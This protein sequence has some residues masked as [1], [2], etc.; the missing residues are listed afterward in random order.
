[1]RR[2]ARLMRSS[3]RA[4]KIWHVK[5]TA[6]EKQ[7]TC[8]WPTDVSTVVSHD[9]RR[10]ERRLIR[11]NCSAARTATVPSS[12]ENKIPLLHSA[13]FCTSGAEDSP[14]TSS[15]LTP[16]RSARVETW[17]HLHT[18]RSTGPSR[19]LPTCNTQCSIALQMHLEEAR[20]ECRPGHRLYERCPSGCSPCCVM[21]PAATF[22]NPIYTT[23]NAQ[24]FRLLE[25]TRGVSENF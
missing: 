4:I 8:L 19:P 22:V 12:L 10:K 15:R 6:D 23:N 18:W 24:S 5:N 7:K 3:V 16:L 21:R 25:R 9:F 17:C 14:L 1:M 2:C 13:R 20:L 11:Q